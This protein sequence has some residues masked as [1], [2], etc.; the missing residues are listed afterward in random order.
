MHQCWSPSRKACVR[1]VVKGGFYVPRTDTHCCGEWWDA[2]DIW[3]APGMV[4]Q[5]HASQGAVE[6]IIFCWREVGTPYEGGC[7][8]RRML[9]LSKVESPPLGI[10]PR[11]PAWQA[12]ILATILW[13]IQNWWHHYSLSKYTNYH[14]SLPPPYSRHGLRN[15]RHL[16][17][18]QIKGFPT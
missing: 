17:S 2:S 6:L 10:E 9:G 8:E 12:G 5:C 18:T 15:S 7:W 16:Y 4:K 11:S 13:R 14:P 3:T 1:T